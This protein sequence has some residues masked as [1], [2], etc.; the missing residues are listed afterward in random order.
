[1]F[2][3]FY[4]ALQWKNG[5]FN[6]VIWNEN[7]T[8]RIENILYQHTWPLGSRQVVDKRRGARGKGHSAL[9][10]FSLERRA[11]RVLALSDDI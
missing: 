2:R 8:I 7:N 5:F 11:G 9:M 10:H 3:W 4:P 6:I 1:M